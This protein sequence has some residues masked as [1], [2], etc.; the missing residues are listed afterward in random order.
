[1]RTF[2]RNGTGIYTFS[3]LRVVPLV[4]RSLGGLWLRPEFVI[5]SS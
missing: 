3:D 2:G 5:A 1:M 4:F